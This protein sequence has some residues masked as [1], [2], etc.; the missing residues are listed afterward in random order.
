MSIRRNRALRGA[1]VGFGNVVEQGH[2]PA[3]KADRHFNILA[4]CDPD[5]A[6]L[7]VAAEVLPDAHRYTSLDEM[8]DNERLDFVDVASPPATHA[9]IV[10]TAAARHVHVLCEKPLAIR[11]EDCNRI[12]SAASAGH[13]VV[14]TVHNWKYA[15]IF[16]TAKR[17]LRRGE[18]GKVTRVTLETLRVEPPGSAT[19]GKSWR[20]DPAL[21]GGGI[22]VDHGWHAFYLALYALDAEPTAVVAQ[23]TQR[24]FTDSSVEDTA[25]CTIEF[26]DAS[27]EIFLTWAADA[28]RNAV[29]FTGQHGSVEVADRTLAVKVDGR[30]PVETVFAQALSAGSYHPDWFAAMLEDF[31]EEVLEPKLRGTNFREAETC[32][33]LLTLCYASSVAGGARLPYREALPSLAPTEAESGD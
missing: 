16:R 2:L 26:P 6:R 30:E 17:V 29:R 25:T 3:W 14:F 5:E 32:C 4:V 31:R 33:R 23:T 10:A 21:A 11:M 27:A 15:P 1:I 13:V 22:L 9:E 24:K 7:A 8:F 28:R 20:L 12:R 19:G 18:I